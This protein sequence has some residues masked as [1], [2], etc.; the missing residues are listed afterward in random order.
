MAHSPRPVGT[1]SLPGGGVISRYDLSLVVPWARQM[2]LDSD[3]VGSIRPSIAQLAAKRDD[4]PRERLPRVSYSYG[5][6]PASVK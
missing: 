2:R 6:A 4:T 3:A 5:A 1:E